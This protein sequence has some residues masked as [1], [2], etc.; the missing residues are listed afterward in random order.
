MSLSSHLEELKVKHHALESQIDQEMT[1]PHADTI[2]ISELKK[3][4]LRIKEKIA[5]LSVSKPAA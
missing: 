5:R 3:R 2:K 4:K 1:H